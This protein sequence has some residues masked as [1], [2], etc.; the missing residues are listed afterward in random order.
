[1][2]PV[3]LDLSP[4]VLPFQSLL[5]EPIH[6]LL[7]LPLLSLQLSPQPLPVTLQHLPFLLLELLLDPNHL[8]LLPHPFLG[9]SV[10]QLLLLLYH[11]PQVLYLTGE[12]RGFLGFEDS[13]L[14][15][16]T[17]QW[18]VSDRF[19]DP[20]RMFLPQFVHQIVQLNHFGVQD[21][22]QTRIEVSAH[23]CFFRL[24]VHALHTLHAPLRV[25]ILLYPLL[26]R[27]QVTL[28]LLPLRVRGLQHPMHITISQITLILLHYHLFLCRQ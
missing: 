11:C 28:P 4:F 18:H 5:V 26:L 21:V 22:V 24:L 25:N 19:L 10:Q 20:I 7:L 8:F 9:Q 13:L 23:W 14:L 2:L 27:L 17:S 15:F 12:F 6:L 1:M 3:N 16:E